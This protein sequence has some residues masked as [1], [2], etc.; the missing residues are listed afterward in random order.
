MRYGHALLA[1]LAA[2]HI[3][4]ERADVRLLAPWWRD[5]T[6]FEQWCGPPVVHNVGKHAHRSLV[7]NDDIA[8]ITAVSATLGQ[9]YA[10]V[11]MLVHIAERY[12][13]HHVA[14]YLANKFPTKAS[15]RSGDLGEIIA[16]AYL[17]EECSY[18]VGPSR[19]IDRDHQEWA[20]RGDDVLGVKIDAEN[21]ALLA[22]VEAKSG[23]RISK[24]VV[25]DARAGL[26]R[27][28]GLPAPQSLS[29]FAERLRR[30]S[31]ESLADAV[32]RIQLVD[33]I[34]PENVT[35]VMFLFTGSDPTDFVEGD[36]GSYTGSIQQLTMTLRVAAHPKFISDVYEKALAYDA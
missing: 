33:G 24:K 20:M 2:V 25:A 22:K 32:L 12:G 4:Y 13:K 6:A 31:E 9:K 34:R 28:D 7:S 10:E 11:D 26:E 29:Q 30:A 15:A 17:D 27:C 16:T 21:V 35:H 23:K 14:A 36:L 5:M 19:L 1:K 8:G 3:R 18:S